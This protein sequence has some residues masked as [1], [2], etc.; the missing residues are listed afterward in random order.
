MQVALLGAAWL[1][2]QLSCKSSGL[3]LGFISAGISVYPQCRSHW[4]WGLTPAL[5][6]LTQHLHVVG[7]S[8]DRGHLVPEAAS[9][10][11]SVPSSL[12]ETGCSV[13]CLQAWPLL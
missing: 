5:P 8:K 12:V 11:S 13:T 9:L 3:Q 10:G 2:P 7:R 4:N 1:A 6:G